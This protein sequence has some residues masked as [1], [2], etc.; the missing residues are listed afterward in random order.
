MRALIEGKIRLLT[1]SLFIAWLGVLCDWTS[2]THYTKIS[3]IYEMHPAY[4]PINA[5][6]L[7]SIVIPVACFTSPKE[8]RWE[9]WP[10]GLAA[11]AWS[12]CIYNLSYINVSIYVVVMIVGICGVLLGPVYLFYRHISGND[13]EKG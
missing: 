8:S 7:F 3:Y 11:L 9:L 1:V 2:T 6:I 4:S 5:F 10:I 13:S 12:G